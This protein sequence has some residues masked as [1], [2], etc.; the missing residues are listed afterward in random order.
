MKYHVYT[1]DRASGI[2]GDYYKVGE[3]TPAAD[4]DNCWFGDVQL[5][6]PERGFMRG[7]IKVGDCWL[8]D[9]DEEHAEMRERLEQS[10]E[11]ADSD[12]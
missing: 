11:F 9:D 10:L 3:L 1:P 5:W 2:K 6:H 12:E 4:L 7:Q 8:V